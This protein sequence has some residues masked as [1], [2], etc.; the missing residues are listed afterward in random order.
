VRE[1]YTAFTDD[2]YSRIFDNA[3]F[4]YRTLT[5][6][7][8]QRDENGE[9]VRN[10]KGEPV[11]DASQRDTENVPLSE[12]VQAYFE[13]EVQPHVPDAWID[14]AKTKIGYEIPFNRYFYQY[15]PPRALEAIDDDLQAL[16]REIMALLAEVVA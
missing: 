7:R 8:P 16:G 2:E 4:G 6:E 10:R 1:L 13:R 15:T 11:A 5:V 9:I 12:D 14:D 3:E